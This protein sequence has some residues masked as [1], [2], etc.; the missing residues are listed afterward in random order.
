MAADGN[1][2]TTSSDA[3][4]LS[5][6]D[7]LRQEIQ[8]MRDQQSQLVNALGQRVIESLSTHSEEHSS[9]HRVGRRPEPFKGT[10][11]DKDSYVIKR[12]LERMESYWQTANITADKNKIKLIRSFLVGDAGDEYDTRVTE[13]GPFTTYAGLEEWL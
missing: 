11:A 4:M 7:L 6:V 9:V 3:P 8:Q 2:E 1:G 10:A 12:W 13:R 5:E